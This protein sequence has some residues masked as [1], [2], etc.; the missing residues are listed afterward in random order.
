[1]YPNTNNFKNTNNLPKYI[2]GLV[3]YSVAKQNK[4]QTHFATA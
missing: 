1:M 2:F 3:R 4:N